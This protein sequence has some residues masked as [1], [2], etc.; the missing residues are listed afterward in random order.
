LAQGLETAR[1]AT[2]LTGPT[3]ADMVHEGGEAAEDLLS[4][5]MEAITNGRGSEPH[6]SDTD[7]DGE[8][9]A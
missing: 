1:I 9:S 5:L 4:E 7:A 3:L 2:E 6:G 8:P